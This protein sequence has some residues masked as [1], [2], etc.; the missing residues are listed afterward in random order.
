MWKVFEEVTV[1]FTQFA[2]TPESS[3]EDCI[4][5]LEN[6]VVLLYN[7]TSPDDEVNHARKHHVAPSSCIPSNWH[8]FL[9]VDANK[10]ELFSCLSSEVVTQPTHKIYATRGKYVL[11]D[12]SQ[13][14]MDNYALYT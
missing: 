8:P 10:Q 14:D 7:Q 4:K 6:F 9:R 13:R 11:V 12:H 1:C 5:L 3:S 2:A